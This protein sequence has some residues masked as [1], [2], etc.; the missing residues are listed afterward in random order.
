ME[1]GEAFSTCFF[2][3]SSLISSFA[4]LSSSVT[5]PVDRIDAL[6]QS[7]MEA[8]SRPVDYA[9]D[10]F[11]QRLACCPVI[12]LRHPLPSAFPGLKVGKVLKSQ[13]SV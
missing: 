13:P 8:G 3:I 9:L 10:E 1:N 12:Q 6:S 4:D 2:Q 7:P 11:V 5:A